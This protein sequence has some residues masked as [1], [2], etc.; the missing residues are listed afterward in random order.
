MGYHGR[1]S[2]GYGIVED[3]NMLQLGEMTVDMT[4]GIPPVVELFGDH[5]REEEEGE[6]E[7][8]DG[9]GARGWPVADGRWPMAG[10]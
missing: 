6:D 2:T 7:E 3:Y 9:E 5:G 8:W 10:G 4:N 1:N